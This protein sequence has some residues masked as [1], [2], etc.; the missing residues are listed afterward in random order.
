MRLEVGAFMGIGRIS[1][2]AQGQFESQ[3]DVDIGR[4][5]L[6]V[7]KDPLLF[8]RVLGVK[9]IA[10]LGLAIVGDLRAVAPQLALGASAEVRPFD[11]QERQ[12]SGGNARSSES[13]SD[14]SLWRARRDILDFEQRPHGL[15]G[16]ACLAVAWRTF[17]P[18]RE[19]GTGAGVA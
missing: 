12:M 11:T 10:D 3:F 4:L 19:R 5:L 7:A 18:P 2:V 8:V 17:A 15:A 1:R 13:C 14:P 9:M 6:Q 16:L